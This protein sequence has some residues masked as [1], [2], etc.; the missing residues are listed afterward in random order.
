MGDSHRA[1]V[2]WK[3]ADIDNPYCVTE[4]MQSSRLDKIIYWAWG[5]KSFHPLTMFER[6]N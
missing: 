4:C 6:I 2:N 1:Y 3:E 5:W